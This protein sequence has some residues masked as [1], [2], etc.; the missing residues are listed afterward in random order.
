[1][2]FSEENTLSNDLWQKREFTDVVFR[3][4]GKEFPA[5]RIVLAS[6]SEYFRAL[7]YGELQEASMSTIE[8]PGEIVPPAAFEKVLQ[9]AYTR[10]LDI[11]EPVEVLGC[12]FVYLTHL[13]CFSHCRVF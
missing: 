11:D 12:V 5:H 6:Q 8:M 2:S 7:L 10:S 4:G 1:M 9:Y 13:V 3:V